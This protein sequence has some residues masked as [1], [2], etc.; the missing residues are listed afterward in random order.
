[1]LFNAGVEGSLK[2]LSTSWVWMHACVNFYVSVCFC[3]RTTTGGAAAGGER[4][5]LSGMAALV[6]SGSSSRSCQPGTRVS[7]AF[8]WEWGS[9]CCSQHKHHWVHLQVRF[10]TLLQKDHPEFTFSRHA[11][12]FVS[13]EWCYWSVLDNIYFNHQMAVF[14]H[15][16]QAPNFM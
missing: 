3:V 9:N 16:Y 4:F 13:T 10:Y 14:H 12:S 15:S 2:S 6:G 7:V 5:F 8:R 1:M 11:A